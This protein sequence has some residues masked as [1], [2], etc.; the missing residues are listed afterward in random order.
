[1]VEDEPLQRLLALDML[2]EAGFKAIE[3]ANADQA[4]AILESRDDIR[5]LL[6]DVDMP[7]SMDGFKLAAAVRD[8][9]PPIEIIVVSGF[10]RPTESI[11]PDRAV[12]YSKPYDVATMVMTISQMALISSAGVGSAP[13]G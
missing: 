12:F 8:R 10:S 11:L 9:W 7:G 2:E 1:M 4:V 6:T 13:T 5:I 3:A